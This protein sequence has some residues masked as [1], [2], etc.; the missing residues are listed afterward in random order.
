MTR[1]TLDPFQQPFRTHCLAVVESEAGH[2][3]QHT[4]GLFFH[5][6]RRG[7]VGQQPRAELQ[8]RGA[9]G[10]AGRDVARGGVVKR[11]ED[12]QPGEDYP[13]VRE[14]ALDAGAHG[15]RDD[16]SEQRLEVCRPLERLFAVALLV[17]VLVLVLIE[18]KLFHEGVQAVQRVDAHLTTT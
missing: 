15:R 10:R 16:S 1:S 11:L 4:R 18:G 2:V 5:V 9:D 12:G 14:V 17:F 7:G 3:A 13:W 6:Q 8:E